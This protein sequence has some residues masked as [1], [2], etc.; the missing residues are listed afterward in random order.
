MHRRYPNRIGIAL[1]LVIA[2]L[3]LGCRQQSTTIAVIPRAPGTLLWE[4]TQMGLIATAHAS[5]FHIDWNAPPDERDA[6]KQLSF[7]APSGPLLSY[8]SND[9]QAV[10]VRPAYWWTPKHIFALLLAAIALFIAIQVLL[11]RLQNRRMR[12]QLMERE[13][14]AFEMHDTLAQS[15]TGIA[16]QL[17]AANLETRGPAQVQIH[18]RNALQLV[19]RSHQQASQTIAALRPQ[20]RDAASIL[21]ALKESAERVSDRSV[22][23]TTNLSG[24]SASLPLRVTDTLF[25]IGQE[26]VSNAIQHSGCTSLAIRLSLA[27][28][29]AE[30]S[31]EDNGHGFSPQIV[32]SGIGISAM[33]SRAGRTK[34]GFD[35]V[36]QPGAGTTITVT[37]PLRYSLLDRLSAIVG[38]PRNRSDH[39]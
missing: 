20:L 36:T 28:H 5:G 9:D 2:L 16:Y 4:P 24:R 1:T 12:S 6:Q 10:V 22:H 31:I 26:A 34:V 13:E 32:S 11:H 19:Q 7:G 25:R 8:V 15:F 33:R 3:P 30:L 18:I 37:A 35:L 29:H 39:S 38:G 14:L 21:A 17:Q 27:H 23:I